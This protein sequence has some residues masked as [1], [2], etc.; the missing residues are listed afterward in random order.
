MGRRI[1]HKEKP[2]SMKHN[3]APYLNPV[4]IESGSYAGEGI[5]AAIRAGFPRIISI[6]LSDYYYT[7]CK[8]KFRNISNIELYFGDS[9][10][11]LPEILK[12]I[13]E[14]CTFWL[15]GHFCQ[16]YTASGIMPVPL[17]EELKII[18]KHPIKDH[19]L[20]LD[21]MRL[22][23]GHEAEW[24]HLEYCIC[25]VEEMIHSINSNYKITYHY[26]VVPNDILIAEVNGEIVDKK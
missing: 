26:G 23:R 18:A 7:F 25:D 2:V 6:E 22:L 17:M 9:I 19:T 15:D 1:L 3:F 11:V 21:D 16:D 5:M 13:N 10:E 4:F 20:I 24:K 12:G 8:E 14:R